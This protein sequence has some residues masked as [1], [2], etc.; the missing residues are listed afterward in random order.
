MKYP[1]IKPVVDKYVDEL[2]PVLREILSSNM[3]TNV[4]RYTRKFED[5]ITGITGAREAVAVSS[6]T[7]GLILTLHALGVHEKE[8]IIPSFTFVA[9]A[10]AVYWTRNKIVYADIDDTFTLDPEDVNEK[11]TPRTGAILAVHMY[12]NPAHIRALE[13]IAEDNHIPL[14]FDAAHAIGA[15][16]HGTRIGNLGNA[17]VFSLSP[18]KLLTTVEGGVVVTNDHELAEKIRVLRNYGMYPDYTSDTPGLNARMSEVHAAIG[19]AQIE[20][21]D[22][23]IERRNGYVELYRKY[24]GEIKGIKFQ[25]I[26]E[27]HWSSH[28]DFSFVIDPEESGIHRDDAEKYLLDRGIGVKKYFYPPMHEL[29]AYRDEKAKLPMTEYVSHN[30]LSLPI[31][32]EM[33]E[34]MIK[35]ICD[36]FHEIIR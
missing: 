11:I 32:N 25:R 19:L 31:Y 26:P 36:I 22:E 16:Y 2:M 18:T 5:A 13:E 30:I 9:T 4:H 21:L 7:S 14:I 23:F 34:E 17:E 29:K 1:I 27:G 33:S 6:G 8:V 28:K 3:L 20:D 24:L 12:G 10:A 35:E 15:K